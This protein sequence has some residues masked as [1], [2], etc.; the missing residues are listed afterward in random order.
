[1]LNGISGRLAIQGDELRL[2]QVFHNL[3]AN[4]VKYSP[5]GGLVRVDV[6]SNERGIVVAVIDQGIGIPAAA[7]ARMFERFYRAPNALAL[8]VDGMGIGLFV[9]RE[10]VSLHGGTIDVASVESAG[11]TFTVFLPHQPAE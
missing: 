11:S 4:A 2:S 6:S 10:I 5:E 3:I 7:R 8:G 1:V 9:V